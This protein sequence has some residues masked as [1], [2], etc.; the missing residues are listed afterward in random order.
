M[1]TKVDRM[2]ADYPWKGYLWNA[3]YMVTWHFL[4]LEMPFI[5]AKTKL[6]VLFDELAV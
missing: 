6:R 1:Q 5:E 2:V 3:L 4:T